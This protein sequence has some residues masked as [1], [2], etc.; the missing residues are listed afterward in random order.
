MWC[1][2]EKVKVVR[3][4]F[5]LHVDRF[6][7]ERGQIYGVVGPNGSGKSTFLNLLALLERPA[8]GTVMFGGE[9][10]EYRDP[11]RL[12][13]MRRK[14]AYLL[15]NPY[16]FD[17]SVFDNI[18]YGLRV[19]GV[20]KKRIGEQ[21]GRLASQLALE[22]LLSRSA[23]RLSGGEAQRVALARTLVLDA[24]LFLLDEPT[25]NVDR[26]HVD[27]VEGLIRQVNRE[28]GACVVLTTHSQDQAYRL[29][30]Q[31]VSII[32][33]RIADVAYENV[34]AGMLE[35]EADGLRCVVLPEG[36][37]IEVTQG[38]PGRAMVAIDPQGV[39]LST[40]ELHSSALNRFPGTIT[41]VEA[42]GG[43]L[44]VFVDAG[45]T[46]CALITPR[47]FREL[48]LQVGERVWATFKATAAQ[49]IQS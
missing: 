27:Q 13:G 1:E 44:R 35:V 15:Q 14:I 19:R 11:D 38:K 29:A 45:M 4:R 30:R 24:E 46:L 7:L 36:L 39:I 43:S 41:R 16:L 12:L 23:R 28:Q 22:P 26:R 37:R 47:S 9:Q 10:V 3:E 17:L 5:A 25:A 18:A 40:S 34:F 48:E 32:D 21:V 6:S 31:L 42:L 49:V 33:G 20:G 8:Q 2:L